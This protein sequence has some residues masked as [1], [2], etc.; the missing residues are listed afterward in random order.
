MNLKKI[1]SE[2]TE[3]TTIEQQLI[4]KISP[5]MHIFMLK[6]GGISSSGH[7]VSFPQE[8]NEPAQVLPRLPKEV[9]II[10]VKRKG[11]QNTS[12]EF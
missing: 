10:K 3:L 6:H 2:L 1:P 5:C 4:S 8:V 11:A 9:K 7:C 12:K